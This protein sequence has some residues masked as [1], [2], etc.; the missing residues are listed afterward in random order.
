MKKIAVIM[1]WIIPIFADAQIY[2]VLLIPDSLLKHANAVMRT[3]EYNISIKSI[4]SAIVKQK[5]AI[6]VLNENGDK[7]AQFTTF[8]SQ[9]VKINDI[10]GKLYDASGKLIKSVKKK[11]YGRQGL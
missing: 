9:F 1:I 3:E 2:N 4:G 8:Y 5:Y 10:S 7:F 11:G 6:T